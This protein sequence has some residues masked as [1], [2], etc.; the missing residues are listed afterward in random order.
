MESQSQKS[1]SPLLCTRG[2]QRQLLATVARQATAVIV[3]LETL[4]HLAFALAATPEWADAAQRCL[5]KCFKCS[6]CRYMTISPA[7][8][9]C[10]W[11]HVCELSGRDMA[12][13]S[14]AVAS[15]VPP[16]QRGATWK[17]KTSC[18]IEAAERSTMRFDW[19]GRWRVGRG[20]G[21]EVA[22]LRRQMDRRVNKFIQG[23]MHTNTDRRFL[24]QSFTNREEVPDQMYWQAKKFAGNYEHL[25]FA[26]HG[27]DF[28]KDEALTWLRHRVGEHAAAQYRAMS[29]RANRAD[30]LRNCLLY[31]H[32]GVW[33]DIE[34]T[35]VAPLHV[36]FS[37]ED[38]IHVVMSA[39]ETP[40][41]GVM[42]GILAAPRGLRLYHSL[43][44][45]AI[46]TPPHKVYHRIFTEHF[47]IIM[48]E[49]ARYNVSDFSRGR[50]IPDNGLVGA[51][52]VVHQEMCTGTRAGC[53]AGHSAGKPCGGYLDKGGHCC[54]VESAATTATCIAEA[55][56]DR[57][58][59]RTDPD[60]E[61]RSDADLFLVRDP[62]YYG[63]TSK[64]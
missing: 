17:E 49:H 63:R 38:A 27:D 21:D 20:E 40:T 52:I 53:G 58:R 32:G 50:I 2:F 60:P 14:G 51:P 43:M 48:S 12:F 33:L 39:Y 1:P 56:E 31:L 19:P 45:D 16:L 62:K 25:I 36:V 18:A 55:S 61:Q 7:Y 42:N 5:Q 37:P 9:D 22:Q 59:P 26:N 13:K 10:S 46:T 41:R 44:N 54:W 30:L 15:G 24:F 29:S 23:A 3:R 35:L 11:Y 34:T 28:H 64:P 8:K 47:T 57:E 4:A 6:R